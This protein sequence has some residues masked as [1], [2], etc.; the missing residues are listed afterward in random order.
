MG[1]KQKF[2]LTMNISIAWI[3]PTP[4]VH[5][6]L[7]NY[8]TPGRVVGKMFRL[9]ERKGCENNVPKSCK[10]TVELLKV[11]ERKPYGFATTP[12]FRLGLKV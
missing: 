1:I 3:A 6:F 5:P 11:A 12:L 4:P 9:N 8:P 7:N 2:G 10:G